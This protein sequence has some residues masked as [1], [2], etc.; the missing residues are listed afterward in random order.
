MQLGLWGG[1][2]QADEWAVRAVRL[3][4]PR[5]RG[6]NVLV[7]QHRV[8]AAAR[9]CLHL[10]TRVNLP[11]LPNLSTNDMPEGPWPGSMPSPQPRGVRRS[12]RRCARP[13]VAVL[14]TGGGAVSGC[15]GHRAT[16]KGNQA[17]PESVR[18]VAGPWPLEERLVDATRARRSHGSNC[19]SVGIFAARLPRASGSGWCSATNR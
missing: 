2:T 9:R 15:T 16:P 4:W 18:G 5:W 12:W 8:A 19:D 17:H 11:T 3:A 14:V 6:E 10:G 1:S 13:M 7:P